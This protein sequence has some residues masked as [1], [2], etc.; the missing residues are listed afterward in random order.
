V[1]AGRALADR[2]EAVAVVHDVVAAQD[3]LRHVEHAPIGDHTAQPGMREK[4]TAV[5]AHVRQGTL[6]EVGYLVLCVHPPDD[7]VTLVPVFL[8]VDASD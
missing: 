1:E 2:H 4:I 7:G 3:L 5:L 8:H 6:A